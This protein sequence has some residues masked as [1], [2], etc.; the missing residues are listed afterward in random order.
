MLMGSLS[1]ARYRWQPTGLLGPSAGAIVVAVATGQH[2]R[3]A[4]PVSTTGRLAGPYRLSMSSS[5]AAVSD[6]TLTPAYG[7]RAIA[8][9]E[10]I[11][12]DNPRPGRAYEISIELPE[13]TCKCPFSGYP[14]FAVLRLIY[15]PGP[16]VVELKAIKLYIN[17]YRD[18]AISHEEVTNRILDDLVAATEPQWMQLEADFHPR[19]N[20][21]TVVRVSHGSRLAC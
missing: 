20:V 10:L 17:S 21:H 14:D 19:G 7:E 13:F 2:N 12:F 1:G 3:S 5:P 8:E 9:A 11:C 16:R 4:Q 18:R 15:Q 6:R